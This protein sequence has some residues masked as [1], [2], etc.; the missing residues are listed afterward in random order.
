LIHTVGKSPNLFFENKCFFN[1]NLL[2]CSKASAVL[3]FYNSMVHL[4]LTQALNYRA[5][6]KLLSA[7][8]KWALRVLSF[9]FQLFF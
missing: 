5:Q 3:G 1:L 2:F 6:Q 9:C 8:G 7:N 4:H